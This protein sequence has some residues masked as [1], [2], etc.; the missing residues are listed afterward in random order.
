MAHHTIIY[1]R[2]NGATWKTEDYYKLHRMNIEIINS[3]PEN[4]SEFPWINRSMFSVPNE[5]GIFRDQIITFGA[6]YRTLEY[7]WHLWIEKFEELLT[8]LFWFDVTIHAEFEMI[9]D[10]KYDWI[11]NH[12]LIK[13][14]WYIEFPKPIIDWEFE[15]NSPRKFENLLKK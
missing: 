2:I 15:S 9:G 12:K 6:S 4:D 5:Q 10:H 14:N 3:L 1:G 8:K 7:E 11:I 13:D